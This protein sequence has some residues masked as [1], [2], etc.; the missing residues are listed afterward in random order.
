M[1]PPDPAHVPSTSP[2]RIIQVGAGA[3]GLGWLRTINESIDTELA[4]I[5]DIDLDAA[6]RAAASIGHPRLP[7]GTSL[8]ELAEEVGADAVVDV[9]IPEAHYA[10]NLEALRRGLPVLCEKPIAP[11]VDQALSMV[12]AA[13]AAGQLLMISQSR[14]YFKTFAEF[15]R[16]T[17]GLG[18]V[19]TVSCEFFKAPR[20]GGFRE[21]M[22]HPLLVDMAIHHFDAA[23]YLVGQDPVAVYCHAYNPP[24]SWY[25]GDAAA[26]AVFEFSGGARF[27]YNGSWCSPGRETSWNG[28]WRVSGEKGTAAWDGDS[29]PTVDTPN[30]A[31]EVREELPPA[32][33]AAGSA[34]EIAGA[35]AEF[36]HA[37]RT[38]STPS[39]AAHRNVL[40]LVMVEAAVQSAA[41]GRRVVV[42]D[43]LNAAHRA[44]IESERHDD[45]RAVLRSWA[46][47][48]DVVGTPT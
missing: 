12:A 15:C 29:P 5:V 19:G 30:H 40:S 45:V 22:P 26:T 46:S 36:V 28:N 32:A 42:D 48:R 44:A 20:F 4:G 27:V 41:S 47:V 33:A 31:P 7:L 8:S 11:S 24:W 25:D 13:A 43:V 2:L 3:M 14:R 37:L 34:E 10:V 21:R 17:G 18:A 16:L 23:R 9:T 1:T 39:G 6:R 35:L 38:G